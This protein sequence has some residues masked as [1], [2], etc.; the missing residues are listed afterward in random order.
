[1][2]IIAKK[3]KTAPQ[4]PAEWKLRREGGL[5]I[6]EAPSLARLDWL[7]HG[8]STRPGGASEI[9]SRKR[10]KSRLGQKAKERVLNLGFTDWDSRARVLENR[11]KFFQAIGA[12]KL[13]AI[14]L[15]QIHSD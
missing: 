4:S 14:T 2:T 11:E 13:H 15:Q 5:Q 6:L 12:D 10:A 1:M 7:V 9:A 3:K 8:F